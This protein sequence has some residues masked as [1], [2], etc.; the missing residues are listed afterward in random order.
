MYFSEKDF[1]LKTAKAFGD[2]AKKAKEI[3]KKKGLTDYEWNND[4][5]FFQFNPKYIPDLKGADIEIGISY[6]V[7]EERDGSFV[8]RELKLDATTSEDFELSDL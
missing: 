8:L 7:Q 3:L 1:Y 2:D 5:H 4:Y 6:N